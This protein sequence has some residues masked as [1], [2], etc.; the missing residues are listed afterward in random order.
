[1]DAPLLHLCL[2]VYAP[3]PVCGTINEKISFGPQTK[4]TANNDI[5]MWRACISI[6]NYSISVL[7]VVVTLHHTGEKQE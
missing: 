6:F 3:I 4:I 2:Y 7:A 5:D 1:V